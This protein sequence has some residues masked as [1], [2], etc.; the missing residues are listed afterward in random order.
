MR[1]TFT[2]EFVT[3]TPWNESTSELYQTENHC[4]SVKLMSTFADRGYH[5]V[6]ATD[7]Y[8]RVLVFLDR[9]RYFSFQVAPQFDSRG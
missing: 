3:K 9:S 5:A 6:S 2:Y 7:P 1:F 8:S 4:L